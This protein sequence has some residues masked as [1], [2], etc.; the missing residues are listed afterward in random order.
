M[1]DLLAEIAETAD[2]LTNPIRHVERIQEPDGHGHIIGRRGR[3]PRRIWTAEL[4]SLLDQLRHAV[5]PG[6]SYSEE[7]HA[8]QA[9]GSRPAARLD[10]VSSLLRIDAGAIVWTNRLD[11]TWRPTLAGNIRGLVGASGTLA[12]DD[13]RTLLR[14]LRSWHTW[15]AVT[16]GWERPPDA[17]R[18]AACP[19]CAALN[20]IRVRL[21]EER[22][23]C[24]ACGA[25]WNQA[26]IG[27]LA[28][29]ITRTTTTADT[30]VLRTAAVRAR[31]EWEA[32]RIALAGRD[33]PD[34]PRACPAPDCGKV[35]CHDHDAVSA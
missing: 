3:A 4:P 16:S 22:A 24:I 35:R 13:Q 25:W 31:R 7:E 9:P 8:R 12:S 19:A 29:H 11:L 14:D 18:G 15:A 28:A 30:R 26:T 10:A 34:L 27:I 1:T 20:T 21:R 2:E 23:M 6:E 5:I 33:R 32:R 17:P